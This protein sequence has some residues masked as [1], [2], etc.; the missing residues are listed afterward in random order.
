MSST[1]A[2]E[3]PSRNR[4]G[5]LANC[6]TRKRSLTVAARIGVTLNGALPATRAE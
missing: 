3:Q 6:V 2:A 1:E 4:K 5:A